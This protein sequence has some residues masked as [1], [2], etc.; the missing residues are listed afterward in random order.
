MCLQTLQ[1]NLLEEVI[2]SGGTQTHN[3]AIY[4]L[5]ALPAT[6]AAQLAVENFPYMCTCKPKHTRTQ[7]GV[8]VLYM[9]GT[10]LK[11]PA[12]FKAVR[13]DLK[14]SG[15]FQSRPDGFEAVGAKIRGFN[16]V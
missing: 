9:L 5:S 7:Y 15:Q 11:P 13:T 16:A 6:K 12:C 1:H 4:I 10:I 14:P 2:A 8:Y 3:A